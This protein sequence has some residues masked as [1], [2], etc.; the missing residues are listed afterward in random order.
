[1]MGPQGAA[2]RNEYSWARTPRV[3][4]EFLA[5]TARSSTHDDE[6]GR[7]DRLAARFMTH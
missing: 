4:A 3:P 5:L 1:M 7:L 6:L 2:G